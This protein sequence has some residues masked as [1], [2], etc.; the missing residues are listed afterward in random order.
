MVRPIPGGGDWPLLLDTLEGL[1]YILTLINIVT[2]P[3]PL[4]VA[5]G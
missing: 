2:F 1:S 3:L 5:V 4:P